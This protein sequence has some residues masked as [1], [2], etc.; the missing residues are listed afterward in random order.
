LEAAHLIENRAFYLGM[1]YLLEGKLADMRQDRRAARDWYGRVLSNASA[2]YHQQEA[3][4]LLNTP[5]GSGP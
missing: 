4:M 1:L 2:A 5:Y 3:A